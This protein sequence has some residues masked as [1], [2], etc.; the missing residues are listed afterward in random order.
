MRI[1]EPSIRRCVLLTALAALILA[2]PAAAGAPTKKGPL[3]VFILAGQS[4]M[5][6]QAHVRTIDFLGE[7]KDKDRAALLKKFKPDGKNLVTR[8]DVWVANGGVYGILGPGYGG[9]KNY[10]KLG[11]NI[12]PEY[13]F[14]YFMG[15]AL[16]EQVLLIKYA[17]GGQSLYV[18]FRPP[19]AGMPQGKGIKPEDVGRQ[20]RALVGYVHET[21]A[22]LKKHFPAYDERAG[23]EIA[24]FVWFQGFNDM[25]DETGRKEYGK[26][27]VCLIR[28]LRKEFNAPNM[29]VVVGVMGVNGLLNEVGKQKD[30][31]DGQRLV[32]TVPEFQ[33]NVKAIEA[34]PLL[35]PEVVALKT[36]G[37][38]NKD[39]DLKKQPLTPDEKAMLDRATSNLGY[40]YYGEGRFFILLGKAFADT[41]LDLMKPAGRA[42]AAEP[43]AERVAR[44]RKIV[45]QLCAAEAPGPQGSGPNVVLCMADD[46]GWGDVS[47][48]GL[49]AIRTP[50]LDTMAAAGLRFNRF[51]AQQ[52]CSP[53]RAA[54][55]TGRHPNRMGVFWPGM[56]LRKQEVTLA[57]AVKTAGYVTGHFGKWHLNGVAGPGKPIRLDDPLGPGPFG[58]DE[59]FSV[60]NFFNLNWTFSR[61]GEEVKTAGDGSDVIV[62]EAL[63]FIE[64]SARQGKPFLA[65]VWFGS[66]HAPH[67][68]LPDDVRAAGGSA[69]FG[70]ILGIDR[71][72]GTLRGGLRQL[73][74]A[75]NTLVWYCSDNGGWI[76]PK[77]PDANG[78]SGGLRGRKGDMWEG[79]IRVP[80]V[81]EWPARIRRPAVAEMPAGVVDIYPTVAD[82]IERQGPQPGAA[83][84]RHQSAAAHRRTDDAKGPGRWGSGSAS[85]AHQRIPAPRHGTTIG[86]SFT[87]GPAISTNFTTCRPICRK[88]PISPPGIR[89]SSNG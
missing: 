32:N 4:N 54:V 15:E 10:D 67:V 43:V 29:K 59:W 69:Y 8:D 22:N 79:G 73:G 17:P 85:A 12:G 26:N 83:V 24:G 71:A 41:M 57:Q 19:G 9:R 82:I 35:H 21:L 81:I 14:G 39:R 76:D 30:V 64:H 89:T 34:A 48:N 3:K 50:T 61:K 13:A 80:A 77:A 45:E 38:L 27:L 1:Q 62:A 65:V 78:V 36:A 51:Y 28:D 42:D 87:N 63:K 56:P 72:M 5:D 66:P 47:Y 2:S 52:S 55:M 11:S 16:A 33:G 40:H 74:I 88:R 7:D 84:G 18:N 60:S 68:A 70:Q 86:T 53:T 37:W 44:Q 6:G 31:R 23:Y 58:F 20:Y 49:K 75:D 25:F 46:Q